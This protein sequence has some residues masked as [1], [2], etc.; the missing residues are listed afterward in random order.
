MTRLELWRRRWELS[1]QR[2]DGCGFDRLRIDFKI[3]SH[4]VGEAQGRRKINGFDRMI[5]LGS[6]SLDFA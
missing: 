4:L 3:P 1:D 2:R 6:E 5:M